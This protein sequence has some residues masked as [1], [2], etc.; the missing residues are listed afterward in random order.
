MA[1]KVPSLRAAHSGQGLRGFEQVSD[2]R[3]QR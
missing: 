2:N 3:G 1:D